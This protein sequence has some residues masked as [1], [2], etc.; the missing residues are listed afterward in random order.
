MCGKGLTETMKHEPN[1]R[2]PMTENKSTKSGLSRR[3]L[4]DTAARTSAVLA[5][6]TIIPSS[7]LGLNGAVKPSERIVLGGLGIGGRGTHD[8]KWMLLEKDVQFVAICDARKERREFVKQLADN[9][10]GNTD[11]AMY[12][13]MREFLAERTDIDAILTATGDRWHAL[14]AIMCMR[15]GKDVYSEKPSSMTIAEG[16][17]VAETAKRYGRVYQT[18]TQRLSEAHH[19]FCFEMA[20]SGR[21]GE[22][23]TAY[24]HISRGAAKIPRTWKP[25]EPEPPKDEVFWDEW[26]GPCPWRPYNSLYV[27]GKWRGDYD[28][29]TSC[30]GEW[31]AHTFAQAQAGLNMQHTSPVK[32]QYVDNRTGDGMVAT[33]ANGTKMILSQG[34]KYWH[35]SCG[36]RFDGDEGWC[37]AADGYTRPEVS[38][39][40]MLNDYDKIIGDY[41]ART[42]R[43]MNHV[44]DFFDCVKSRR[45]SVANAD[46]MH[47]S[48][49]TVH[50]ANICM[51]LGRDLEYDPVKAEFINDAEANRLRSR[52]MRAPWTI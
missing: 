52:A 49:N 34:D 16:Q 3:K 48:M 51:W 26:L 43:P 14:S 44:R 9:H 23:H 11:C 25:A 19:V 31:G 12:A 50:C 36:E 22:V 29:H 27:K 5:M 24:A 42:Q 21:L 32:Y 15:A 38:S 37:A 46:V 1:G 10:H 8:L 41:T 4:I 33:F 7:A 17:A 28:F 2:N 39:F 47:N 45:Q 13:D 6:P 40:A 20:R 30:I 18:G 35:G